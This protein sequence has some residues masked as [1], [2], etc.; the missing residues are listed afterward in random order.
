[1]KNYILESGTYNP[2][3]N[4][5]IE[6]HLSDNI[7]EGEL[8][9][10]LWQ[11]QNTVVLGKN[12]NALREC[13][14]QLLEQEGG[15]LARRSSGGGAVYQD[16]GNLNYTFIASQERYDIKRQLKTVQDACLEYGITTHFSGR[17]DL[18]TED[19]RKFSGSAFSMLSK[20]KV[21]HG[22]LM[23]D[24]N[25][26]KMKRYLT[27]SPQKL[28][29]RGVQS[30]NSRVCNLKEMNSQLSVEGMR[31]ALC[32]SFEKNY[33]QYQHVSLDTLDTDQIKCNYE[34][35]S[36]W[37]FRYGRSPECDNVYSHKFEWGEVEV[38]IRLKNL[39][40]QEC[41]VYSDTLEVRFPEALET[42]LLNQRY[43]L[44]DIQIPILDS[45]ERILESQL[46]D[47]LHWLSNIWK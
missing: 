10:Y 7:K 39:F 42:L 25:I 45:S 34:K 24:V 27:P 8:W 3:Q 43:D 13:R 28:K 19:G 31:R 11:N 22:T 4:L 9:L 12:Q 1:M 36:S 2:W 18:L 33:G 17:N 20:G 38:Y 5:A 41:S 23:I 30:V 26:D 29:A 44:P 32:H 14:V 47:T 40:I 37:D 6:K 15:F 21:Q 16:L 35:Y 46:K